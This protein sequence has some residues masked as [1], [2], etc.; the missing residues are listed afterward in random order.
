M[1]VQTYS[2]R[3]RKWSFLK[4]YGQFWKYSLEFFMSSLHSGQ[5]CSKLIIFELKLTNKKIF[6]H[7]WH[8][9][10]LNDSFLLLL[11]RYFLLN[12]CLPV[13]IWFQKRR[14]AA[15]KV[16]FWSHFSFLRF[17]FQNHIHGMFDGSSILRIQYIGGLTKI[18]ISCLNTVVGSQT[19][20]C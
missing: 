20:F 13:R 8:M 6:V 3:T 14:R 19:H 4:K 11:F 17:F 16:S 5:F 10:P 1:I 9:V 2:Y 7:F 15:E 18:I 12:K